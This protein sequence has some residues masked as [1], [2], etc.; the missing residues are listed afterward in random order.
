MNIYLAAPFFTPEQV[1]L[2]TQ[3]ETIFGALPDIDFYSPRQD[4]IVLKDI[5][6]DQR[7]LYTKLVFE[8][9]VDRILWADALLAVVDGHDTGTVWEMGYAYAM[10]KRIVT[11][12]Q[13]DYG[14]N[15][16]LQECVVAHVRNG[17]AGVA[18][19]FQK[20]LSDEACKN[21]RDFN[22]HTT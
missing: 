12:T 17:I 5:P 15:V 11:Y 4:G 20:E 16:M 2:V 6:P 21:F 1:T 14:L 13:H 8:K 3:L 9:N 18:Y 22:P 10:G 7:K 19:L